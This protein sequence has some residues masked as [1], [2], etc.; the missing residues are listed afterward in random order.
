M[1]KVPHCIE[2]KHLNTATIGKHKYYDCFHP[3][4]FNVSKKIYSANIK[5]SPQWCPLRNNVV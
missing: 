1:V 5:T 4:L 3:H 2:C